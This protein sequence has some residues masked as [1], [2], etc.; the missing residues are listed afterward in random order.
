L[1]QV[2]N[3]KITQESIDLTC[4]SVVSD[5]GLGSELVGNIVQGFKARLG[6]EVEI[7]VKEVKEI[8]SEKSGKFRY[9][10]SK[11]VPT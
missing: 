9:V 10:V 5:D 1:P 11:V 7:L 4:V 3:F 8:P 2:Q 6:Q